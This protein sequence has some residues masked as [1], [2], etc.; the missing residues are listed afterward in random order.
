MTAGTDRRVDAIVPQIT[1][2][3]LSRVFF[4][5]GAGAP[6]EGWARGPGGQRQLAGGVQARVGRHLLRHRQGARPRQPVR[7]RGPHRSRSRERSASGSL[8]RRRALRRAPGQA[9]SGRRLPGRRQHLAMPDPT[10]AADALVCGRF[11]RDIC[12]VYTTAAASGTLGEAARTRLD[13]SSPWSVAGAITAPTFVQGEADTLFPLSEA[14]V[15]ARQIR[16]RHSREVRWTAGGHDAGGVSESDSAVRRCERTS[17]R[18]S[19]TTCAGAAPAQRRTSRSTSRPACRTPAHGP[20]P[21]RRRLRPTPS[22]ARWRRPGWR[23][24]ALSSPSSGPLGERPPRCP[25]CPEWAL[26]WDPLRSTRRARRRCSPPPSSTGPSTSSGSATVRLTVSG[27]Q[28]GTVLFAKVYDVP[29]DGRPQLPHG[30]VVPFSVPAS[31]A[32]RPSTWCSPRWLTGSRRVTASSWPSPPPTAPTPRPPPSRSSG[33][34]SPTPGSPCGRCRPG[35]RAPTPPHGSGWPCP[36]PPCPRSWPWS[37]PPGAGLGLRRT[38]AD[39]DPSLGDVP[40]AVEGLAKEYADGFVA[41]RSADLRVERDQ[42]VG[43]LGPNGA[44]KTTTL[45]MLMGLIRPTHGSIRVFG[46]A[47]TP[48]PRC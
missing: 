45:R 29:S 6:Q 34:P 24:A 13:A 3:R 15:T 19:T 40:V 18:G 10:D 11:A 2:N 33:S 17:R 39:T 46:H 4:P 28:P 1:W 5:N 38:I 8:V 27:A 43:L 42:V 31:G 30:Q 20:R 41:V 47:V 25:A 35:H 14:D 26:P 7:A 37:P 16:G 9:K 22:A 44:G 32:R 21:A 36:W 23:S 48:A 12:R